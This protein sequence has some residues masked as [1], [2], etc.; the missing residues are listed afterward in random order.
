LKFDNVSGLA[1]TAS[2]AH[3]IRPRL[4]KLS[5]GSKTIVSTE[6]LDNI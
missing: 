5:L 2:A 6:N 3:L 1:I 4:I